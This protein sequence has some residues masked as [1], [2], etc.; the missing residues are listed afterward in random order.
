MADDRTLAY[1]YYGDLDGTGHRFGVGSEAWRLQLAHVDTLV[2]Q[3][4]TRLPAGAMLLV[5]A[6]HGMVDVP[7]T[8]RYDADVLPA[9]SDGVAVMGGEGRARHV[10]ARPGAE[11]DVLAAWRETL[12]ADFTVRSRDQAVAAGWFGPDVADWVRPR[13][14]DVVAAA[15]DTAAVVATEREPLESSLVGMHGSLTPAEQLVPLLELRA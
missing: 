14:G 15:A 6:D 10:Y 13:I 4:A 3:V 7:Q 12:G 5:T 9:L 2:E 8:S 11:A 1:C